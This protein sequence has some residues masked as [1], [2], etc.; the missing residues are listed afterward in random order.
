MG[1][2]AHPRHGATPSNKTQPRRPGTAPPSR[3]PAPRFRAAGSK[4]RTHSGTSGVGQEAEQTPS[5]LPGR[6]GRWGRRGVHAV[7]TRGPGFHPCPA[8]D[9]RDGLAASE[10]LA[11]PQAGYHPVVLDASLA[12]AQRRAGSRPELTD[13][14][15]KAPLPSGPHRS[16]AGLSLGRAARGPALSVTTRQKERFHPQPA[17]EVWAA[18]RPQHVCQDPAPSP[19]P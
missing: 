18:V 4:Y 17:P 11:R 12:S 19:R 10:F 1:P 16:F 7:P 2:S 3:Q 14:V 6:A 8:A 13:W 5:T 15:P 9:T